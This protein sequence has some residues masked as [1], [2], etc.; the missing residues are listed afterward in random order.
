MFDHI[1]GALIAFAEKF[2]R[3]IIDGNRYEFILD[4]LKNL[5]DADKKLALMFKNA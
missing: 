1:I 5:A 3:V 2:K 4:G